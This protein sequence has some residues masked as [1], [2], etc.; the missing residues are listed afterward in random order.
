MFKAEIKLVCKNKEIA[1]A[2][3]K[4]VAPDNVKIP[5]FIKVKTI[6]R[7]KKVFSKI[8]CSKRLDSFM[9]TLDDLISCIQA[10]DKTLG[11]IKDVERN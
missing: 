6:A 5:K 10:A 1:K 4:A 9:Y 7:S 3:S 2:I 11:V 8:V